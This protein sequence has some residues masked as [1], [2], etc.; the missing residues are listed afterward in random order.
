MTTMAILNELASNPCLSAVFFIPLKENKNIGAT[1]T[2]KKE[3][4]TRPGNWERELGML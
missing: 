2:R 4:W 3:V 1:A